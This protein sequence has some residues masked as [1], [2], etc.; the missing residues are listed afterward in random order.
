VSEHSLCEKRILMTPFTERQIQIITAAI[1]LISENG[2]QQMTIKN[3]ANKIGLVEGALYRHFKSK[4]DILLGILTTFRLS[5]NEAISQMKLAKDL[6]GLAK[7]ELLFQQRFSHFKANPALTAV[8]FSEEIFQN[9]NR[10]SSEV[11][12]LMQ[13]SQDVICGIIEDGQKSGEIRTDI[14]AR[15]FS[16]MVIGSLRMIVTQWRLSGFAFDLEEE[17]RKLWQSIKLLVTK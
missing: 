8:I 6:G 4:V 14:L 9:D 13:E 12:K 15:Q 2:I 5:N 7:L 16:L 1:E 10:L 3:L 11:F 17:G